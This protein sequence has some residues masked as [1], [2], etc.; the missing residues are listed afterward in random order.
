VINNLVLNG[1]K[2]T[3]QSLQFGFLGSGDKPLLLINNI[4]LRPADKE[5]NMNLLKKSYQDLIKSNIVEEVK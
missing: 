3:I 2:D 4:K 1:G 5:K